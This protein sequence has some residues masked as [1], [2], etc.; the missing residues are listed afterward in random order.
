M[1]AITPTR[2]PSAR[3]AALMADWQEDDDDDD[4]E[5]WAFNWPGHEE[6]FDP[7][8]EEL[9]IHQ[10]RQERENEELKRAMASRTPEEVQH[11]KLQEACEEGDLALV[12]TL[13]RDDINAES[14]V[15]GGTPLT[16]ACYGGHLHI[17]KFLLEK[18]A[19]ATYRPGERAWRPGE[20]AWCNSN[21]TAFEAAASRA[22]VGC[23]RSRVLSEKMEEVFSILRLLLE[24]GATPKQKLVLYEAEDPFTPGRFFTGARFSD[25]P[26][27]DAVYSVMIRYG[28]ESEITNLKASRRKYLIAKWRR[29]SF[30]AG[31]IARY[32]LHL[33]AAIYEPEGR[34]YKRARD[35]FEATAAC[36]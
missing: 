12:Q 31:R 3:I 7:V 29:S 9:Y 11:D 20:K 32:V 19:D 8:M 15:W 1:S 22:G 13:L 23:Q 30:R 33:Q 21:I 14:R 10:Q 25:E 36:E 17:V 18:G 5:Q 4:A 24:H 27:W 16:R 28:Y 6:N 2:T 26:D 34:G 35:E